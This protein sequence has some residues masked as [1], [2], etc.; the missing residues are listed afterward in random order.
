VTRGFSP[1]D[2]VHITL[3]ATCR[4]YNF[5]VV[6]R[7]ITP[8]LFPGYENPTGRSINVLFVT[9]SRDPG[10]SVVRFSRPR[11]TCGAVRT[12]KAHEAADK[13]TRA[14][15]IQR[16][17]FAFFWGEAALMMELPRRYSTPLGRGRFAPIWSLRKPQPPNCW[18]IP[19]QL[20]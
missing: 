10:R 15:G 8:G 6:I 16:L 7:R 5:V 17:V 20:M 3:I 12:T 1:V 19:A 13:V 9:V 14:D 18:Y 11:S 4:V 2:P